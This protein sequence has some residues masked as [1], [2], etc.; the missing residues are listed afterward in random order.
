MFLRCFLSA[1]EVWATSVLADVKAFYSSYT[2]AEQ[3][4]NPFV[5]MSAVPISR[6]IKQQW[7]SNKGVFIQNVLKQKEEQIG[8]F[9]LWLALAL[10]NVKSVL[11]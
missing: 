11:S 5:K 3:F 9:G 2:E 7:I 6:Q 10:W 4:L 8:S 1:D